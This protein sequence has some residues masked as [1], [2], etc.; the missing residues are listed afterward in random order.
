MLSSM[1]TR[2]ELSRGQRASKVLNDYYLPFKKKSL[3]SE[4]EDVHNIATLGSWWGDGGEANLGRGANN[5]T[6]GVLSLRSLRYIQEVVERCTRTTGEDLDLRI[7]SGLMVP[8]ARRVD[9]N[10][11]E[12]KTQ[13]K[14][15]EV[16]EPQQ[17]LLRGKQRR[18][19]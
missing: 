14:T 17:V 9:D 16:T 1:A 13:S 4:I 2:A 12:T 10:P 7:L 8:G 11:Q 15:G 18:K 19:A 5:S 6:E 3:S